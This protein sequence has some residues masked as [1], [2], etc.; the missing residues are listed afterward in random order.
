MT[1][2]IS[3]IHT[4]NKR[5]IADRKLFGKI[6]KNYDTE[7][8]TAATREGLDNANLEETQETLENI[9]NKRDKNLQSAISKQ[10]KDHLNHINQTVHNRN[11]IA[12]RHLHVIIFTYLIPLATFPLQ[13]VLELLPLPSPL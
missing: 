10:L 3:I 7:Q 2:E 8:I 9:L 11:N 12:Y 1:M 4:Q 5:E 6:I 13:A